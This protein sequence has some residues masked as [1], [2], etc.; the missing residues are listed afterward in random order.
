MPITHSPGR[1][2]YLLIFTDLDGT[3]LDHKTYSFDPAQEALNEVEQR[4]IPLILCTSKTRTEV[5]RLRRALNNHHPFIVENGGAV[6]IPIDYFSFV[7]PY[8][9]EVDGYGVI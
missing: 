6:F 1:N 3:L 2:A 4:G 5:E 8:Q 7:H 9:R